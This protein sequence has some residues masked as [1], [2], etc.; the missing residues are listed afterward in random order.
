M[1]TICVERPLADA[2]A[3]ARP[4]FRTPI[5]VDSRLL[6]LQDAIGS[7]LEAD[8]LGTGAGCS[9]ATSATA[10]Q[11]GRIPEQRPICSPG[12]VHR[13]CGFFRQ[14]VRKHRYTGAITLEAPAVD[15]ETRTWT[16][17]S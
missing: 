17:V 15:V 3:L 2:C 6:A 13:F 10:A 11:R 7:V 4:R 5:T 1:E 8:W 16:P 14:D 12:R 9:C